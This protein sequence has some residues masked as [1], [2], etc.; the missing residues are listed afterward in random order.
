MNTTD[1]KCHNKTSGKFMGENND[2]WRLFHKEWKM[3]AENG[4]KGGTYISGKE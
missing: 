4:R 3:W 2:I 1:N